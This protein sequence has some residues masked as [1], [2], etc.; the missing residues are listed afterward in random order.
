LHFGGLQI[1]APRLLHGPNLLQL[2]HLGVGQTR[3][4]NVD[5][6]PIAGMTGLHELFISTQSKN[7]AAVGELPNLQ[8]LGLNMKKQVPLDFVPK[9]KSLRELRLVLGGREHIDDAA[10][11]KLET[12]DILRVRGLARI[13]P[14]DFPNLKRLF[15]EEQAQLK[16]LEFSAKNAVLAQIKVNACKALYSTIGLIHLPRLEGLVLWNNPV[17]DF[18][19]WLAGGLPKSLQRCE[20]AIGR[21]KLDTQYK[22]RLA[23]LG[24]AEPRREDYR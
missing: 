9:L 11:P 8:A 12:L 10:H 2:E 19:T 18:E 3:R 7:I 23:S 21:P 17:L 15:I 20:F 14:A 22:A 24:Y 4:P 1:D 13:Q 5:L 6:D 16:T